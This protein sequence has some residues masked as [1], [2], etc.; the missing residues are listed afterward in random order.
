MKLYVL[1]QIFQHGKSR[2]PYEK[3]F[4]D[5]Q[6]AH[7]HGLKLRK[8]YKEAFFKTLGSL[9]GSPEMEFEIYDVELDI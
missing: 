6:S 3:V 2:R 9:S 8:E 5:Y 7:D 1:I 4:L